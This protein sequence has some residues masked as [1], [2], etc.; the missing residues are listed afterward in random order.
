MRVNNLCEKQIR[1][2]TSRSNAGIR[3]Y[4]Q[5]FTNKAKTKGS[6][7]KSKYSKFSKTRSQFLTEKQQK[8]L[9]T[10]LKPKDLCTKEYS[11][12]QRIKNLNIKI[13]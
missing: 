5:K 13:L 8:Q 7:P 11:A 3:N 10:I 4:L 9:K 2:Q 12:I 1:A 6:R